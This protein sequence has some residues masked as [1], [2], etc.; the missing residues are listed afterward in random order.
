MP[1]ANFEK[2]TKVC[3]KCQKEL[4]IS[5]FGP[6]KSTTDGLQCWCPRC[7]STANSTLY[8]K[9]H[10][11]KLKP[12]AQKGHKFC[13]KCKRELSLDQFYKVKKGVQGLSS[14]CREC[15]GKDGHIY[16]LNNKE[17]IGKKSK[18]WGINH[19]EYYKEISQRPTMRF[20]HYK[21]TAERRGLAFELTFEYYFNPQSPTTFWQKPCY[22]CGGHIE[23]IGLD[24]ID[25]TKGY[26]ASN[27]VSCCS[28]CNVAKGQMTQKEF[29]CWVEKIYHYWRSK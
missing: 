28:V 19:K 24:R 9:T 4:P 26:T 18:E 13:S 1:L 27:V 23:T 7:Q 12:I 10:P 17:D 6:R 11:L 2:G 16:Y 25:N 8:R 14:A 15:M 22:Y 5:Q 29:K 20:G 3:S 21:R